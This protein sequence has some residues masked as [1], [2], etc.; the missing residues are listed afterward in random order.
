[1]PN[2]YTL[3]TEAIADFEQHGYDSEDRLNKWL[4]AINTGA[5]AL[6][7]PAGEVQDALSRSLKAIFTREVEDRKST[8]LN[9]S[10]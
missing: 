7:P 2:F 3:I 9:S 10:H 5:R 8:R 4:E 6:M 1:M